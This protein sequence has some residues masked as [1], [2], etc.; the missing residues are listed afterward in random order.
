MSRR[1]SG[2]RRSFR[3]R[4][5]PAPAAPE[6]ARP[7]PR[8]SSTTYF[9]GHTIVFTGE[10]VHLGRDAWRNLSKR[11]AAAS[12]SS[13]FQEHDAPR[14]MQ[15]DQRA[16]AP[17]REGASPRTRAAFLWFRV[18]DGKLLRRRRERH[19]LR[20]YC[21]CYSVAKVLEGCI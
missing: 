1:G 10:P 4:S 18:G 6:A 16:G 14:R 19:R 11:A 3:A 8:C 9:S 20:Q 5:T 15:R 7:P 17:T 2:G 12:Y 21:F 13:R